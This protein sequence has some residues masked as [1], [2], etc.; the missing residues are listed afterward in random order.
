M[1]TSDLYDKEAQQG[2]KALPAWYRLFLVPRRTG[3][4]AMAVGILDSTILAV[5]DQFRALVDTHPPASFH[6]LFLGLVMTTAA[7]CV[8]TLHIPT[9]VGIGDDMMLFSWHTLT[10]YVP[11]DS[12]QRIRPH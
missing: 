7:L 6:S 8:F 9:A 2:A 3:V 4:I 5:G 12:R 10:P 1:N 11:W